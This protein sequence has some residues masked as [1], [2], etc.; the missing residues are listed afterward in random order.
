[1]S[2]TQKKITGFTHN[3]KNPYIFPLLL[4]II[5]FLSFIFFTPKVASS[6]FPQKRQMILQNFIK[7]TITEGKINPQAYWEFRE[8]YSPGSFEFSRRGLS[9]TILTTVIKTWNIPLRQPT[10]IF[11]F[12]LF[13]SPH[14]QSVDSLTTMAEMEETVD[15]NKLATTQILFKNENAIIYQTDK[16][17]VKIIFLLSGDEMKKANGFFEYNEKDKKLTQGKYWLNTTLIKM[18]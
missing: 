12:L 4:L 10:D 2:E 13:T 7:D 6:L 9:P 16:E 5:I 15:S 1:M 17:T 18:D 14:L 3:I 8:F 11:P